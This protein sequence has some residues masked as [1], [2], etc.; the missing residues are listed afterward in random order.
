MNVPLNS[1]NTCAR[2]QQTMSKRVKQKSEF[3]LL[4]EL[5]NN[6]DRNHNFGNKF[7]ICFSAIG[8][9]LYMPQAMFIHRQDRYTQCT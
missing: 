7:V 9:V 8:S 1:Q 2:V 5:K 4:L 3:L 6:N